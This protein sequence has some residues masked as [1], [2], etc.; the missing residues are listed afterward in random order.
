MN[1]DGLSIFIINPDLGSRSRL[2]EVIKSCVYKATSAFVQT[3]REAREKIETLDSI[4]VI[5]ISFSFSDKEIAQFIRETKEQLGIEAP[6]FIIS[7]ERQSPETTSAVTAL[8]LEGASGFIAEPY[9][10]EE[11]TTLLTAVQAHKEKVDSIV[12]Q[13]RATKFLLHEAMKRIDQLAKVISTGGANGGFA[14]R[15][16][17][18]ISESIGVLYAQNPELY[19]E[20]AV[21]V[22]EAVPAPV[23][24]SAGLKKHR[25]KKKQLQHPGK[26]VSDI[27]GER[28]LTLERLSPSIKVDIKEFEL[29]INCCRAVDDEFSRELSRLFGR[30]A[31][32]WMKLQKEYDFYIE[33][34]ASKEDGDA[35]Q[36]SD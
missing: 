12:K 28:Q 25:Q 13:R 33:S 21:N 6:T 5:F 29:F 4:D 22:F 15:E 35:Q 24:D 30:T 2:R 20:I 10:S 7:I 23:S 34:T 18:N 8:Y 16:L 3:L 9:S 1:L 19:A 31:R 27:M 14:L 26:V 11:L 17:K 32:D 36:P